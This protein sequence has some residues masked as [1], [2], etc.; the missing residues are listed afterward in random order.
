MIRQ[1]SRVSGLLLLG[2]L[3]STSFTWA[4]NDKASQT[5][6]AAEPQIV[7]DALWVWATPERAKSGEHTAATYASAGSAQQ[8]R[9]LGVPNV[10]LAGSGLPHDRALAE[11]WSAEVAD[12]PRVVWEIMPDSD[13]KE[14]P[15]FDFKQR[16]DHLALL[17]TKY[18]HIEAVMVDD[19]TSVAARHGFKPIHLRN[20]KTLLKEHELPQK[21]WGVVYTMNF[22][23]ETTD[24]LVRELDVINLWVWQAKDLV[25]LEKHVAECEKRYPNKPIVL[26]LYMRDYGAGRRMPLDLHQQ[27]CET[28]LKLLHQNRIEGMVFL[29]IHDDVEV[30]K[31]T[32]DWIKQVDK[33]KLAGAR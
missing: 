15:T 12:A 21:L 24:P 1:Q 22:S 30:I 6:S 16:I 13:N 20:I 27:Q 2:W 32:A 19:M 23:K 25:D 29:S 4:A 17:T 3:L 28:A 31:W 26:G 7:R 18:P 8:A 11:K 9:I 33:Q 5:S 14:R 10:V